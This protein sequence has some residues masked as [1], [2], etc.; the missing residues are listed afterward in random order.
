MRK[1]TAEN[2]CEYVVR[3]RE[4]A[5]RVK[6]SMKESEMIDIFLQVQE[7]DYFHYFLFAVEKA[8]KLGKWWKME[9]SLEIL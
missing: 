3:W 4:Q 7:P 5:A 9:S 2:F 6:P 8:F 1:K